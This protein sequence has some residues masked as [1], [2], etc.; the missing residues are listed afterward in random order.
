MYACYHFKSL[1]FDIRADTMPGVCTYTDRPVP[2]NHVLS[3]IHTNR[4]IKLAWSVALYHILFKHWMSTKQMYWSMIR[5][6]TLK[7]RHCCTICCTIRINAPVNVNPP[8]IPEYS[9]GPQN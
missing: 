5:G 3:D 8:V 4:L 9:Y 6:G 7:S 1:N 2:G